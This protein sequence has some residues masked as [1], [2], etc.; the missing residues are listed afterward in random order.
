M[1]DR[2]RL[3]ENGWVYSDSHP[4]SMVKSAGEWWIL[5]SSNMVDPVNIETAIDNNEIWE[6]F[7]CFGLKRRN[8]D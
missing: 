2:K 5:P 1:G 8:D 3:I 4:D 7:E 6:E